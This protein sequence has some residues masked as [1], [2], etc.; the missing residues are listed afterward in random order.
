MVLALFSILQSLLLPWLFD[1]LANGLRISGE[2]KIEESWWKRRRRRERDWQQRS[3]WPTLFRLSLACQIFGHKMNWHICTLHRDIF[4]RGRC[5]RIVMFWSVFGLTFIITGSRHSQESYSFT[6]LNHIRLNLSAS[7]GFP[8]YIRACKLGDGAWLPSPP[9]HLPL[10]Y[11]SPFSFPLLLPHASP[12]HL[13]LSQLRL[14]R[15]GPH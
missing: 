5:R 12:S 2:K 8:L 1:F 9:F 4:H 10:F 6:L 7:S 15:R 13:H 14:L 11:H 3:V